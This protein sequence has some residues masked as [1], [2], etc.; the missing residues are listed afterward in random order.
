MDSDTAKAPVFLAVVIVAA[1]VGLAVF[2]IFALLAFGGWGGA[3]DGFIPWGV[4]AGLLWHFSYA[5]L[6]PPALRSTWT[7]RGILVLWL[8][9][10]VLGAV[11][12]GERAWAP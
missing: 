3:A 11:G 7:G 6:G 10:L 8:V 9:F 2:N 12:I 5:R 1:W 4:A